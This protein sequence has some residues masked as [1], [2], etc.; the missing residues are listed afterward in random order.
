[1]KDKRAVLYV[2]G[3]GGTA[4]EV[5]VYRPIFPE[6][7]V[8]G[9]DY[10]SE[11]PWDCIDEFRN[12]IY[13]LKQEYSSIS[14]IANSIGAFFSMNAF[15]KGDIDRA[16]FISPIVD[17][18]NLIGNMMLWANVTE[19]EL[20]SKRQIETSFGE[21]LSWEYLSYVRSHPVC[22]DVPTDI[23]YGGKDNMTPREII[24][25]FADG[26]HA[27]LTVMP[28]GEHWF[29]TRE[30]M[31]FLIGWLRTLLWEMETGSI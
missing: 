30:Q 17:M 16:Y 8:I 15:S 27:S 3:K 11:T 20:Q 19:E 2:H 26:H 25:D 22:W 21:N 23:L 14:L 7:E 18:E 1:M 5:E 10:R 31:D 29:H 24:T 4:A 13:R 6:Y 12:E 9:F 28:E